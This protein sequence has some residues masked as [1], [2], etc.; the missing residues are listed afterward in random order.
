MNPVNGLPSTKS[1]NLDFQPKKQEVQQTSGKLEGHEV[2]TARSEKSKSLDSLAATHL[3]NTP[4]IRYQLQQMPVFSPEQL[5]T[6][7]NSKELPTSNSSKSL[8]SQLAKEV[9]ELLGKAETAQQNAE[10]A[11]NSYIRISSAINKLKSKGEPTLENHEKHLGMA[12]ATTKDEAGKAQQ[13]AE[14]IA[15]KTKTLNS[16]VKEFNKGIKSLN[17]AKLFKSIEKLMAQV[18]V[19]LTPTAKK[20]EAKAVVDK[21]QKELD[22]IKNDLT[23]LKTNQKEILKSLKEVNSD[24]KDAKKAAEKAAYSA[25]VEERNKRADQL[26]NTL[27]KMGF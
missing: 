20:N 18:K 3:N 16:N 10:K 27:D 19:V 25:T 1:L 15:L 8:S 5:S 12:L 9:K 24:A 2:T 17:K 6:M 21:A 14:T 11:E 13:F 7:K 4:S 22:E 26:L 23:T